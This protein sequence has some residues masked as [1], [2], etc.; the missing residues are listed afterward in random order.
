MRM[1]SCPM[2]KEVNLLSQTTRVIRV[3][4]TIVFKEDNDIL[5][6]HE[7]NEMSSLCDWRC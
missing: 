7:I 4:I 5:V 2:R 1:V 6:L 3:V